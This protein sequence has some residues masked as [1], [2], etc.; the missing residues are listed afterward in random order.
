M[1]FKK[2]GLFQ[3]PTDAFQGDFVKTGEFISF[4]NSKWD[5]DDDLPL[6]TSGKAMRTFLVK[7][8]LLSEDTSS[9]IYPGIPNNASRKNYLNSKISIAAAELE[10]TKTPSDNILFDVF[11]AIQYW[12]ASTGRRFYLQNFL[13]E[14]NADKFF[15]GWVKNIKPTYL[16]IISEL[17]K[18]ESDIDK[19]IVLFDKIDGLGVSFG[20]KHLHFWSKA[21]GRKNTLP[22][23]DKNIYQLLRA[24][25]RKFPNWSQY[26]EVVEEFENIAKTLKMTAADVERAFFA[27]HSK[28]GINRSN[29][30]P[31]EFAK[32][33]HTIVVNAFLNRRLTMS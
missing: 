20:T 7:R 31:E 2:I 10:K 15:E 32:L 16:S 27:Y 4:W 3:M 12:G 9:H 22:I 1:N 23:Y 33:D 28:V 8:K 18:E 14:S 30:V 5:W 21:L 11:N 6:N 17:S 29:V 26:L 13:T 19:V 24:D 25:V